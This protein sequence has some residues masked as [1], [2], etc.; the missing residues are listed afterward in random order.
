MSLRGFSVRAWRP[1][2][3][4]AFVPRADFAAERRALGWRWAQGAPGPTWTILRD[5]RVLA[6]GGG[7]ER[8]GGV[9]DVWASAADLRP[10]EWLAC[11]MLAAGVMAEL[12]RV[13]KA[14]LLLA[15][16]RS[17]FPAARACLERLGFAAVGLAADE[18][19]PNVPLLYMQRTA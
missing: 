13:H 8:G 9:W 3:E 4:T 1:G 10:R 15:S 5:G 2:D 14:K 7:V 12:R 11:L 16:C 18:R 17:N 19:L 6:V